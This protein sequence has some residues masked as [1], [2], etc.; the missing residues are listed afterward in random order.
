M[1]R[2]VL[3][4]D[5][6]WI[7]EAGKDYYKDIDEKDTRAHLHWILKSPNTLFIYSDKAVFAG[8][9]SPNPF[10][11]KQV[12]MQDGFFFGRG[13][14]EL[15]KFAMEWGKNN[16]ATDFR[17][18]LGIE[19]KLKTIKPFAKKLGATSLYVE[20]YNIKLV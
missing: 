9:L 12:I 2:A 18:S 6:D 14:I 19:S 5:L 8:V 3:E 4:K 7:Y 16:G 13:V 1:I 10:N 17:F 20:L 15:V 11:R